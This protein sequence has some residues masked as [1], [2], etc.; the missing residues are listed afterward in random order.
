MMEKILSQVYYDPSSP[1]SY[2]WKRSGIQGQKIPNGHKYQEEKWQHG[3]ANNSP[4]VT[5]NE[6]DYTSLKIPTGYYD[7]INNVTYNLKQ[8]ILAANKFQE[9]GVDIHY[10]SI[11][12]R[13]SVYVTNSCYL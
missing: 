10:V 1:A 6:R 12:K 7:N 3:L 2:G 5:W 9:D 4:A 13:T 11:G 8:L